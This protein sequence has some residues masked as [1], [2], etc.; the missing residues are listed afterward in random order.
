MVITKTDF[1]LKSNFLKRQLS[2][3]YKIA[4]VCSCFSFTAT[5]AQ[6]YNLPNDYFYGLLTERVLAQKDS[7][8][9]ASVKPYIPFFSDKY[10]HVEDSHRVLKY[11]TEDQFLDKV[12]FDHLLHVRSK[13]KKYTLTV[14]P[15]LNLEL[16]RDAEDT[17]FRKLY[18]NTRGFIVTGSIGKDFYFETMVSENQSLFPNYIESINKATAVVPGQGRWKTFNTRG[19]D[20]SFS[21]GF[22]SYQPCKNVN[23]QAGHGKHKIGQGYRSLFLSD[24]AFNYPFVRITQNYFKG[25]LQYTN[26]YAS[27]MNLESASTK[28]PPHTEPLFQKKAASFQHLSLNLAK[29]LN[30]GFFQG[31]IWQAADKRNTQHFEWQYFNPVI[32]TNLASY[33]LNNKNNILI[34][35]DLNLKITK[36]ISVYGQFMA[37][38]LSNNNSKGNGWG[39]QAGLKYFNAFTVKNLFL[40]TEYNNVTEASY[41]SPVTTNSVNQSYSHYNQ[42][43]AFTP[44]YGEEVVI[45]ADY[46]IKRVFL[47]ARYH[48]QYYSYNNYSLFTNQIVNLKLGYTINPAYNANISVG[49]LYRSQDFFGFNISNNKTAYLYLSF[50]TSLY[51]NYYDF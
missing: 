20:Y 32:F 50:K 47:N 42:N 22:F 25:R 36:R 46:K 34:G 13:N 43:I 11:I 5:K 15:L 2:I 9:H 29:W 45:L 4:L 19:F 38:D 48:Y 16:G 24:N 49:L 10:K 1:T 18:T 3:L 30:V 33:G 39:Y 31:M 17:L 51:N 8:I 40:Q 12:F 26:I 37:D 21:S 27:F 44:G 35:A 6:F 41:L 28:I 23:I 14:D 7:S